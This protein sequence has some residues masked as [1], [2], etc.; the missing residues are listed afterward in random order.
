MDML[1]A[2]STIKFFKSV[3]AE[4]QYRLDYSLLD[5]GVVV[6][7]IPTAE[8]AAAIRSTY[9]KINIKS[10]FSVEERATADPF[11]LI[12]KQI[13][14]YIEVYGL[15]SPGLFNLEVD[16][17]QLA[18]LTYIKAIDTDELKVLI[19][20]IVTANAPATDIPALKALITAFKFNYDI[21]EV[22]NNELRVALY[23][24]DRDVFSSGD[25]AVRFIVLAAT[26]DPMLI[27]S[28][29]VLAALKEKNGSPLSQTVFVRAL[30]LHQDQL[31]AVFNR[32]KDILLSIKDEYTTKIINRI[33]R[34]SKKKHVPVTP[35]LNKTFI[36]RYFAGE[37]AA[38]LKVLE[39]ISVR[40]KLKFLTLLEYKKLGLTYDTFI[41]R[42]GKV[43]NATER[44]VIE[45][46]RVEDLIEVILQSLSRDLKSL[47]SKN[48]LLD[49][50]VDYGL[51]VSRKQATGHLPFGTTVT[52]EGGVS[53][54]IYWHNEGGARDLD[55]ST[56][57]HLGNRT[58]W[59]RMSGYTR[60]DV[61]FSGDVTSAPN[62]ATEFFTFKKLNFTGGLL[63]N[64]FSGEV[65]SKAELVVGKPSAKEWQDR[66]YVREKLELLS[67]ET[68]IGF[69]R[70]DKF[71]IY[72]GR[73]GNS[74]I[75][76][77]KPPIVSKALVD[78]WTVGKLLGFLGINYDVA[79]RDGVSY[80]FDLSYS[81]FTFDKLEQ[82]LQ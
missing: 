41:I 12:T 78:H 15:D 34:L 63:V 16:G 60:D 79:K 29:A 65:G 69:V 7:F 71:V 38:V 66:T 51:P 24:I 64:I 17:K 61:V 43:W 35:A 14:H 50:V 58:G 2:A 6:D 70:E 45:S 52:V 4:K 19:N 76:G 53:A 56:I 22:K 62:G 27:K 8:Q 55:L 31:A 33:A 73:L 13:M 72:S 49:P 11:T 77:G 67:K 28:K 21:N 80:D 1:N 37:F 39:R 42:N 48:I 26:E 40:D 74:H 47:A 23:D 75:S 10:L 25:D 57:D 20:N 46:T 36:A 68:I 30:T 18:T 5:H 9:P 44:K 32:H 59:G 3:V 54:G 81:G 82:M